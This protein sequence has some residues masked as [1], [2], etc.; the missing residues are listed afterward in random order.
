MKDIIIQRDQRKRK[1]PIGIILD[2]RPATETTQQEEPN[3]HHEQS[4]SLVTPLELNG[5]A[6]LLSIT[7]EDD[8]AVATAIVPCDAI[9]LAQA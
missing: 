2:P 5:Q 6:V 8:Y 9:D 1:P 4:G 3:I 7:H